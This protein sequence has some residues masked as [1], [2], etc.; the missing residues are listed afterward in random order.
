VSISPKKLYQ[1]LLIACFA[2]YSWLLYSLFNQQADSSTIEVCLIKRATNVPCPSCGT[3]R[4][5]LSLINGDPLQS[6]YTNPFGILIAGF[7][8]IIPIWI[9]IDYVKNEKTLLNYY[10]RTI[11]LLNKPFIAIPMMIL[12]LLNWIWNITKG[13]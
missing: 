7:M 12:V 3:T 13:L 4:S 11:N 8:L 9:L 1:F 2:G 6:L 5:V 10:T